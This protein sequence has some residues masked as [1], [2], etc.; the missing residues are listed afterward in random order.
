MK[1]SELK[2]IIREVI[3][4]LRLDIKAGDAS[5]IV[6]ESGKLKIKK[7]KIE[8][9]LS[10]NDTVLLKQVKAPSGVLPIFYI[11]E[12]LELKLKIDENTKVDELLV[13][14]LF[15][16]SDVAAVNG[17]LVSFTKCKRLEEIL[18]ILDDAAL[19]QYANA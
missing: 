18:K 6:T 2:Q 7:I 8:K 13:R 19:P 15:K 16:D 3:Q 12:K 11:P 1:K 4:E 17:K 10:L 14:K 9:N 5:F